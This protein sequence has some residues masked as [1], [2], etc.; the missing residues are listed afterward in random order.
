[1][2]CLHGRDDEV[3]PHTLGRRAHDWLAARGVDVAWR[4]YP[5]GHEVVNE[6]L[7]DIALWLAERLA[8]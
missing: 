8:D 3:V 5:M 7:R 1:M 4:D 6:E 2:L